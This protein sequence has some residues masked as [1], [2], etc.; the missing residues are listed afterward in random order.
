[1]PPKFNPHQPSH[2]HAHVTGQ[3]GYVQ[4]PITG[5]LLNPA[6]IS[7]S[8]NQGLI[9]DL[10]HDPMIQDQYYARV[11]LPTAT[12][13]CYRDGIAHSVEGRGYCC[14]HF[15][16]NDA[17]MIAAAG[18]MRV[19]DEAAAA[20]PAEVTW[21]DRGMQPHHI[22]RVRLSL[23]SSTSSSLPAHHAP[24]SATF[25][26]PPHRLPPPLS[27]PAGTHG[28]TR[29]PT[30]PPPAVLFA[31]AA[32][33]L[34]GP[35]IRHEDRSL[36]TDEARSTHPAYDQVREVLSD[37][38]EPELNK[39]ANNS[40]PQQEAPRVASRIAPTIPFTTDGLG[41]QDPAHS[42]TRTFDPRLPVPSTADDEPHANGVVQPQQSTPALA[43]HSQIHTPSPGDSTHSY[44]ETFV[45]TAIHTQTTPTGKIFTVHVFRNEPGAPA[46]TPSP[47]SSSMEVDSVPE[48]PLAGRADVHE[49]P[50]QLHPG[51]NKRTGPSSQ[52]F[53]AHRPR[54]NTTSLQPPVQDEPG[55]QSNPMVINM[56]P[57]Q[58]KETTPSKSSEFLFNTIRDSIL[59]IAERVTLQ[60]DLQVGLENSATGNH[61]DQPRPP[62]PMPA[63]QRHIYE[64]RSTRSPSRA[65]Q[66]PRPITTP[67]VFFAQA[68]NTT[69]NAS[70]SD[71]P[72][73][74]YPNSRL[75]SYEIQMERR[76]WH[77][78]KVK[79][80][81]HQ[82]C[83]PS[84][85]L[86]TTFYLEDTNDEA[87]PS[88]QPE[89]S[90]GQLLDVG[91]ATDEIPFALDMFQLTDC[92]TGI[93]VPKN[94]AMGLYE[95]LEGN[96][97]L[98]QIDKLLDRILEHFP[99]GSST[100]YQSAYRIA[101]AADQDNHLEQWYQSAH[102]TDMSNDVSFNER[103]RNI[104]KSLGLHRTYDMPEDGTSSTIL[105]LDDTPTSLDRK[106]TRTPIFNPPLLIACLHNQPGVNVPSY[107][108]FDDLGYSPEEIEFL[109][110]ILQLSDSTTGVRVPN[111]LAI[112]LFEDG[113]GNLRLPR[114][115]KLLHRLVND[116]PGSGTYLYPA[117][118]R[119]APLP[120]SNL[121]DESYD[122]PFD[123]PL[124]LP[125]VS[126]TNGSTHK[127]NEVPQ[128]KAPLPTRQAFRKAAQPAS[129]LS[130][131]DIRAKGYTAEEA[132]FLHM[133]TQN[134]NEL[135]GR[136]V[137]AFLAQGPID[138]STYENIR[139][140]K[141]EKLL[142]RAANDF[143]HAKFEEILVEYSV[144]PAPEEVV[145]SSQP[146]SPHYDRL[147]IEPITIPSANNEPPYLTPSIRD[148]VTRGY[149][150]LE[151]NFLREVASLFNQTSH[152]PGL[153]MPQFL[154]DDQY[155]EGTAADGRLHIRYPRFESL[156]S[157]AALDFPHACYHTF[158]PAYITTRPHYSATSANN[159]SNT[160]NNEEVDELASNDDNVSMSSPNAI[161]SRSAHTPNPSPVVS[162][163]DS[164][165]STPEPMAGLSTARSRAPTVFYS[166]KSYPIAKLTQQQPFT[167]KARTFRSDDSSPLEGTHETRSTSPLS[168]TTHSDLRESPKGDVQT[169]G[170]AWEDVAP[171]WTTINAEPAATS[172]EWPISKQQDLSRL[173]GNAPPSSDDIETSSDD[174]QDWVYPPTPPS[175]PTIDIPIQQFA[176][177][178]AGSSTKPAK[179]N[180]TIVSSPHDDED[181]E[182]HFLLELLRLRITDIVSN[183]KKAAKYTPHDYDSDG[184]VNIDDI[185]AD[186]EPAPAAN[187]EVT[188]TVP[189]FLASITRSTSPPLHPPS[190]IASEESRNN[191]PFM[192]PVPDWPTGHFDTDE[193]W[194]VYYPIEVDISAHAPYTKSD[195]PRTPLQDQHCHSLARKLNR[196]RH[197]LQSFCARTFG[198]RR[199]SRSTTPWK[200]II[201]PKVF[202][203]LFPGYKGY[204]DLEKD[205]VAHQ[206]RG[207]NR[208]NKWLPF[209]RHICKVRGMLTDLLHTC[210][211]LVRASGLEYGMQEYAANHFLDVWLANHSANG[212]FH[213]FETRFLTTFLH[214]LHNHPGFHEFARHI[215]TLLHL[216]FEAEQDLWTLVHTV[217][218]RLNPPDPSFDLNYDID[219]QTMEAS[220]T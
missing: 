75:T 38:H 128:V 199:T 145:P 104:A 13:V 148:F 160:S 78:A 11:V 182:V 51:I 2:P 185:Y 215:H 1:M 191:R 76:R 154:R 123:Y 143:P 173:L 60:S 139:V 18:L 88:S 113:Q 28:L 66:E 39:D 40:T 144:N 42:S 158:I 85:R 201:P 125:A 108:Q 114:I 6:L 98:P 62:T 168:T 194:P 46:H 126:P 8:S 24:Q 45:T 55:A 74:P 204:A 69:A 193:D 67:S 95:D 219:L 140:I 207:T 169:L 79:S 147:S 181:A 96:L 211:H 124:P 183:Y 80:L 212:L 22:N 15:N 174:D 103:R 16:P 77:E 23:P 33:S 32:S 136:D 218:D 197:P 97:R 202:E 188:K 206:P 159:I 175:L 102:S 187:K 217:V 61:V 65:L 141:L 198:I 180:V 179:R 172:A 132:E 59:I 138:D 214:F 86:S 131:D 116:F 29:Q 34:H 150:T 41:I 3:S 47:T 50:H 101:P 89:P 9:T 190:P 44:E 149:S 63:T 210:E 19:N 105:F 220:S 90:Y 21:I 111:F 213:V 93:P 70:D 152:G 186:E 130:L 216:R 200:E 142:H 68:A 106:G 49:L 112:D 161:A 83:L 115:N 155:V 133:V 25:L 189:P 156:L 121:E 72:P 195:P 64:D 20:E 53:S 27:L 4:H 48:Q 203:R 52:S 37:F 165:A 73:Q 36:T 167:L 134:S 84:S 35:H 57:A 81:H 137:P 26:P 129:T 135:E 110:K 177:L 171:E 5:E 209:I 91:F 127:I 56:G 54:S 17:R 87:P 109:I 153:D 12:M 10:N 82:Y 170:V 166:P 71:K 122:S 178:K 14:L 146:P 43:A 107:G 164:Q 31:Q 119:I 118:Y 120:N 30:L 117:G 192:D 162:S 151:R 99:N 94:L 205:L 157:R 92:V 208:Q 184:Q 176:N 196:L 7:L 58:S 163:L 100:L